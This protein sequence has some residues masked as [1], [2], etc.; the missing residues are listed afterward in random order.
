MKVVSHPVG[1]R[2]HFGAVQIFKHF[3]S[4]MS[5]QQQKYNYYG[6]VRIVWPHTDSVYV[7]V[8]NNIIE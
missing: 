3:Q 8:Y 7:H 1:N 5:H 2:H 6:P 4:T